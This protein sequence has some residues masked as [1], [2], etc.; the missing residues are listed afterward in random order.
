[1]GGKLRYCREEGEPAADAWRAFQARREYLLGEGG[2]WWAVNPGYDS[3]QAGAPSHFGYRFEP[4][5][6]PT[7][8]RLTI[9]GRVGA[10]EVVYWDGYYYWHAAYDRAQYASLSSGGAVATGQSVDL[11]GSLVF[12]ILGPDG[13]VSLHRDVE[14]VLG[15]AR[16]QSE[17]SRW[18]EGRWVPEQTLVWVREGK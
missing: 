14:T 4:G 11:H 6:A 12:E 17:S 5:P 3:T 8:L 13:K 18:V 16:F 9:T 10:R 1:M 2:R 7:V 15:P